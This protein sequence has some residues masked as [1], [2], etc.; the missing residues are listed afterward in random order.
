MARF[1]S[2]LDGWFERRSF[3]PE[4]TKAVQ[5]VAGYPLALNDTLLP[6]GGGSHFTLGDALEHVLVT[7]GTGSGKTSGPLKAFLMAYLRAGFGGL[8]LTTKEDDCAR[9]MALARE[10]GREQDVIIVNPHTMH[11][12]NFLNYEF[13]RSGRGAG[14]VDNAVALLMEAVENRS[15]GGSRNS[16]DAYWTEGVRR[17]LRHAMETLLAAG[18]KVSMWGIKDIV[19]GMPFFNDTT[20]RPEYP[21]GSFL[22]ECLEQAKQRGGQI[23]HLEQ[24]WLREMCRKGSERQVAGIVSTFTGMCDPFLYGVVADLFASDAQDFYAPDLCRVG[25]IVVIDLPVSEFGEVGRTAQLIMKKTFIDELLRRQ[26]L[27]PGEVPCFLLC[28]EYQFLATNSDAKLLQAGRSS[29]AGALVATQNINNLYAAMGDSANAQSKAHA[30]ISNFQTLAFCQNGDKFTNEWAA[31]TIGRTIVRRANMNTS[32]STS[33]SWGK[34]TGYSRGYSS[35]A[36]G[37]SHSRNHSAGRSYNYSTSQGDSSGWS[38]QEAFQ[39]MPVTFTQLASGGQHNRYQVQTIIFKPG[40]HF[41]PR[42]LP[43]MGVTFDQRR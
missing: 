40:K 24:Y 32:N 36:Q 18:H 6:L 43:Y 27:Q 23:R 5:Q 12:F 10:C 28:D 2:K 37:G 16:S 21:E 15:E 1:L 33:E 4:K 25:L 14:L 38:E 17:L 9:V 7:G 22:L 29:Y 20:N 19:D 35:S 41:P 39:V 13:S 42:G 34:N 8:V 3:T 26:G 31:E 30:S 11:R